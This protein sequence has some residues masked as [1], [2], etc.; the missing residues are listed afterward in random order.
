[1]KKIIEFFKR[2]F[3]CKK[4]KKEVVK[5]TI[6]PTPIPTS[7]TIL[8]NTPTPIP[9][10][11]YYV[12]TI[13]TSPVEDDICLKDPYTVYSGDDYWQSGMY[14]YFDTDLLIPITNNDLFVK[15]EYVNTIYDLIGQNNVGQPTG[16][17]CHNN[18]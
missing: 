7:T 13:Q 4:N 3:S 5:P 8:T 6:I 12:Y 11:S 9:T 18:L 2:L 16:N 14:L 15:Q 17:S 1:M 10:E